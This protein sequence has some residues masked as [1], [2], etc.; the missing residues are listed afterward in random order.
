MNKVILKID[1]C[2]SKEF[3]D[4]IRGGEIITRET[5]LEKMVELV[6]QIFPHSDKHYPDGSYYSDE[7]DAIQLAIDKPTVAVRCAIE[8]QKH[9]YSNYPLCLIYVLLWIMATYKNQSLLK[10]KIIR[11]Y[12]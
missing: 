1:L 3:F 12:I 10:R 4:R 6:R 8:C 7:G 9:W 5:V 11:R 2:G